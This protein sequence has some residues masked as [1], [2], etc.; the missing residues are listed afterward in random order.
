[1]L[2]KKILILFSFFISILSFAQNVK[3]GGKIYSNK[4]KLSYAAIQLKNFKEDLFFYGFSGDSGDFSITGFLDQSDKFML[5]ASYI[6]YK[7]DTA[8]LSRAD[9]LKQPYLKYNFS[10]LEDT[11]QLDEIYIKAPAAVIVNED[12]TKYN[13]QRFT[14]LEDRNLESVIKKMPGM[15]VNTDGTI[16]FKGKKIDKILLENDDLTGEGYKAITKNLKP[17]FVEELQAIE[18]YVEDNLLK[19]IINSD[20]IVL[21]LKL[22]NKKT[23]KI[24]GSLDVGLGNNDRAMLTG[25]FI[26]FIGKTKAFAFVNQTNL[27]NQSNN[28]LELVNEDRNFIGNNKIIR[29]ELGTYNPFDGT[30]Y[31]INNTTQ[32]SL[33]AI[34]RINNKFKINYSLYYLRSKLFA[35]TSLQQTYF[36]P[37]LVYT[38][39]NDNSASLN[40][41]FKTDFSTDY[42]I[43]ANARLWAKF[44][45][46]QEPTRFNSFTFS[47]F[48]NI[49]NDSVF[50]NQT[51]LNKNLNGELK[52]TIKANKRSAYL[53]SV[54][55]LADDV[56]QNY[57]TNSK[58]Y[59]SISIFNGTQNL[60]QKVNNQNYKVRIDFEGLKRYQSNFIYLNIGNEVNLFQIK[61]GLFSENTSIRIPVRIDF[62]NDNIFKVYQTYVIGKYVYDNQP[63]KIKA[64][65]KS[66]LQFI[67]NRTKES[68]NLI[69]EPNLS[70]SYKLS[71][72]QDVSL[73]YNYRNTNPQPIEYYENYILTNLRNLSSGLA[74]FYNF[75]THFFGFNY[76][77]NDFLNS[78]FNFNV[79]ANGTYSKYGFVYTNL[80][81]DRL[82][83]I[84]K[85]PFR[86]V[87]S[88]NANFNVK[89]FLPI[90]SLS[91]TANYTPS[92]SSY[93]N[94]IGADIKE[95]NT[96]SQAGVFKI[97]TGF[98]SPINFGIGLQL[99]TNKIK[100]EGNLVTKNIASNYTLEYK[101]K[102]SKKFFNTS[103]S[104][105]F[106]IN[107]N[108]FNLIDTEFQYNPIKGIFKYSLQGKNLANIINFSSLNINEAYS[109]IN[110]SAILGR[111]ILFNIS[112]SVK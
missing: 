87:K 75:N 18:H 91:L 108:Q 51:D 5:I 57:Q 12:T 29:Q 98:N 94:R 27:A 20:D 24:V 10:L 58:L 67:K 26:S 112:M 64:Q 45:Y 42:S 107:G 25:N 73:S 4:Q 55:I 36:V 50:Q 77:F 105:F 62:I 103:S 84:R 66:T 9:L 13:V 3:I 34:S 16:F 111:Y 39:N 65:L 80:F 19:G 22:K 23:K 53:F 37:N 90:L 61:S 86:G 81:I 48:D 38:E 11:K 95:F 85:E 56:S 109:S 78:Y 35:Q 44:T 71:Q 2:K 96:L 102:I 17:E 21:N 83:Y 82:N 104:D 97:N 76:N 74:N 46:K 7:S 52:Y 49:A 69:L 60:F 1:M 101:Y 40:K 63:I 106:R 14:S 93:F 43:K 6:G 89:K 32:V 47:K 28:I 68:S 110:S 79:T 31:T 99:R 92:I 30:L 33:N 72:I 88:L 70:F 41:T 54:K 8:I 15:E 100:S 59:K